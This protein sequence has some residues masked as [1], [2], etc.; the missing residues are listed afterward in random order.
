MTQ[1]VE[2]LLAAEAD[3][4]VRAEWAALREA[5]LPSQGANTAA[6]NRPHVT[7]WADDALDPAAEDALASRSLEL[8]MRLRLGA[9]ACFGR[10][11]FVLV[12]LVVASV[13]LLTL[14][15]DIARVCGTE[16]G[17]TLAPG[18]WTPHVTLARRLTASQVGRA[19]DVLGRSRERSAEAVAWR[20]WDGDRRREWLLPARSL[21]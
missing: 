2:L 13:P 8:P 9:V 11:R 6:T 10:R 15:A 12:R 4:H 7:L 18:N 20:R 21:S 19:V 1:S 16:P 14:H 5:G 3:A 17:S